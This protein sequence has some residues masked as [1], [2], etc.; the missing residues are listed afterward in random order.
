MRGEQVDLL[1]Q[2]LQDPIRNSLLDK[3]QFSA[4]AI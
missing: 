1:D 4:V 2:P 3:M